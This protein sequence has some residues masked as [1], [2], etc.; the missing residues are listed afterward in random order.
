M[1]AQRLDTISTGIDDMKTAVSDADFEG[2]KVQNAAATTSDNL[3]SLESALTTW[4]SRIDATQDAT[5]SVTTNVPRWI[6]LSSIA[7]SFLAIL[8]GAGQVAL[9]VSAWNW[10]QDE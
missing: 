1:A 8:F 5:R 2:T 9:F 4:Q 10:F 3:R 6:D 7:V